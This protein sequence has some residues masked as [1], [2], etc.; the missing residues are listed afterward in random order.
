MY[1]SLW[2]L[3]HGSVRKSNPA[4]ALAFDKRFAQGSDSSM[5]VHTFVTPPAYTHAKEPYGNH[6][7]FLRSVTRKFSTELT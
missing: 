5:P 6:K 3:L 2:G 1:K 4:R 7:E